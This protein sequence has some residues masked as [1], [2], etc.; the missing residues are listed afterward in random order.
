M[1][2]LIEISLLFEKLT[3]ALADG[4]DPAGALC[5]EIR[6][7]DTF[8][9]DEADT[10]VS[11]WM[12]ELYHRLASDI[13]FLCQASYMLYVHFFLLFAEFRAHLHIQHLPSPAKQTAHSSTNMTL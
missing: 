4:R 10:S 2:L 5:E 12:H 13:H 6:V 3:A 7:V 1:E 8:L 9:D 11:S